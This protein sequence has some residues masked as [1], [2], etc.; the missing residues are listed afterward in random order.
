MSRTIAVG[1]DI[2]TFQ[3]RVVA[4]ESAREGE[5]ELPRV[6]GVGFAESRGLRHGHIL[7]QGDAVKSV[8]RALLQA[9]KAAGVPIKRAIASIGGIGLGSIVSS[10]AVVI[11]RADSEITE[12]DINKAVEVSRQ[13]IPASFAQNRSI[14]HTIPL[15]FKVD[16]RTVLGKPD[17][18]KGS[19]LEVKTLLITCFENHVNDL[20]ETLGEAGI[21]V[22]D[23]VAAPL[24]A[25]LVTLTRQQKMAGVVLANIGSETVSIV[26][27]ENNVPISLEVFPIGSNDITNDIA[28]GLRV[29]LEEAENIKRGSISGGTYPRKKLEEV[30]EARLSDIFE[31]IEAHLKKLGR[32]GLLPAGIVLTGGGSAIDTV[33]DLAKSALRLPSRVAS[34]SFGDNIRGQIRDASWSVA[35]GLCVIGLEHGEEETI[36]G[37]KLVRKTRNGLMNLLRQFLP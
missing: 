10:G 19:K 11:S 9:S 15:L 22:E 36:T 25:S 8:K 33:G 16:G 32:S 26:V 30:I 3:T 31:L 18:L 29:P 17:S 24:S 23:L 2:G 6:I 7:N 35:Y 28:L 20:L 14:L 1:I 5:R 37:L 21:E 12:L 4:A 34:I 27:F 13:E